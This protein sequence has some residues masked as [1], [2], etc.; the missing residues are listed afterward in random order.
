MSPD[1]RTV[2]L[3]RLEQTDLSIRYVQILPGITWQ[4]KQPLKVMETALFVDLLY[5]REC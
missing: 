1:L 4:E 5:L 2:W 3:R